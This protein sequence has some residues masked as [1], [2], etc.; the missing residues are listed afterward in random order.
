MSPWATDC[1]CSTSCCTTGLTAK[2]RPASHNVHW[3]H[4]SLAHSLRHWAPQGQP[5]LASAYICMFPILHFT[6]LQFMHLSSIKESNV[7]TGL[8]RLGK[9]ISWSQWWHM[10]Y[11]LANG[12]SPPVMPFQYYPVTCPPSPSLQLGPT[13]KGLW[14]PV[15]TYYVVSTAFLHPLEPQ[16][17]LPAGYP[18]NDASYLTVSNCSLNLG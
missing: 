9:P 14:P 11:Y 17:P 10:A 6:Y 12:N 4:P 2:Q 8:Q 5:C 1:S 3:H 13:L 16:A 7:H 15:T 18:V